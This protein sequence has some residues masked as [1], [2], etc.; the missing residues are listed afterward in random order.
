MAIE[1]TEALKY[2]GIEPEKLEEYPDID[3]FKSEFD[4]TFIKQ[5]QVASNKDLANR[6]YGSRLGT[7][8]TEAKKMFKEAGVEFE[9][10]EIAKDAK[11]EDLLTHGLQKLTSTY[12]AKVEEAK[13]LASGGEGASKELQE[14]IEKLE[15]DYKDS[16]NSVA[17]LSDQLQQKEEEYSTS[18]KNFKL[19]SDKAKV[20]ETIKFKQGISPVEKAGFNTILSEKVVF[21][22]DSENKLQ[23]FDAETKERFKSDERAG[24]TLSP[25]QVVQKLAIENKVIEINPH[26]GK[27]ASEKRADLA[28]EPGPSN[29]RKVHPDFQS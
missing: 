6:I 17:S 27:P 2:L 28:P 26:G 24:D 20:F 10:G 12:I 21:D 3:A 15:R 5:D 7:L 22:Y 8:T 14:K 18:L 25:E 29:G 23:A 19:N 4:S 1:A 13:K 16:K 9:D 11:V